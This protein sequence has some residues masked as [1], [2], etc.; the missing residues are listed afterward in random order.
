MGKKVT[1]AGLRR[2]LVEQR[3]EMRGELTALKGERESL[4]RAMDEQKK[5]HQQMIDAARSSAALLDSYLGDLTTL[6]TDIKFRGCDLHLRMAGEVMAKR[7]GELRTLLRDLRRQLGVVM[8]TDQDRGT[9]TQAPGA[10]EVQNYAL[11]V[12]SEG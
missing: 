6:A 1:K 8:S 2:Q 9:F 10:A 12:K 7:L 11:E 5:Q 4:Q 3:M